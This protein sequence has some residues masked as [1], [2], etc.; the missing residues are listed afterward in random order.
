[1]RDAVAA[2]KHLGRARDLS[3]Q[4]STVISFLAQSFQLGGD[5]SA[6]TSASRHRSAEAGRWHLRNRIGRDERHTFA[7]V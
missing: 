3:P 6:G 2:Q 5:I 7:E 1:M 4:N